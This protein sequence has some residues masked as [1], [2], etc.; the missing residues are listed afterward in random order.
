MAVAYPVEGITVDGDLS[1]WPE[2]MIAYPILFQDDGDPLHGSGDFGGSFRVGYSEQEN[3]LYIA[4][5]VEDDSVV[6]GQPG[7]GNYNTQDGCE[8]YL[9]GHQP[10]QKLPVQYYLRDPNRGTWGPDVKENM[11]VEAN[12]ED[13][14]YQ[15]EWRIDIGGA[16]SGGFFLR[17][18]TELGFDI[19]IWD[20][21]Q[22]G[23]A[24]W[25]AWSRGKGKY[26]N[27][28]ALGKLVLVEEGANVG[29]VLGLIGQAADDRTSAFREKVKMSVG[30]QMFFS[31]V[32]LAFTLLHL[33]LFLF[34][35]QTKANLFYSI[36]T[37]LIAVA[38][39]SGFQLEFTPYIDFGSISVLKQLALLT[40]QL[41]GLCFL[42]SL[43]NPKPPRRFWVL[44]AILAVLLTRAGL[45]VGGMFDF[46]NLQRDIAGGIIEALSVWVFVEILIALFKAVRNKK[47]GAWTIGIGFSFFA[48]NLSPLI[49]Q[50]GVEIDQLYWVL[51]PL[52]S[53]SIYLARSVTRTNKALHKQ[54]VQVEDLSNKTQEQYEQIQE[55]NLQIQEANRL[56][57]DF[58]ARM[59]HDLRTPM[60]AIIG[61]TRILLRKTKG[62]LDERQYRNLENVQ[63]SANNLLTL[64]NDVLDLSKIEAG[65]TDIKIGAVDLRQLVAECAASVESLLKPGVQLRQELD[66]ISPLRTD[67]DRMRR[68][69]MNLLSNA[70]KFTEEG[71]II[72]SLKAAAGWAELTVADTGVGIPVGDLPFIFDEFRQADRSDGGKQEGTGLGL[73]IVKRSVE[74]LGGT[75]RVE[76]EE[77][78]GAV[79]T[80]RIRDYEEG[81]FAE[82]AGSLSVSPV[83]R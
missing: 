27:T 42:Y 58:L 11:Q 54:L 55:Q 62:T 2:E 57:S 67:P 5:K 22:D 49:Y 82:T 44:V 18:E 66:Y 28:E 46:S 72:L 83:T 69:L 3:A 51:I 17:P 68:V 71:S 39:F 53:M 47:E 79:F 7:Q 12:W 13:R 16:S 45:F 38:V 60:N 4:V 26:A 1:D 70:V 34:D 40:V 77:G 21:D 35:P 31:G 80:L 20:K 25:I 81:P 29:K 50:N 30:Y 14:G 24:S 23:T 9:H 61:Y 37:G 59:S 33:L 41:F 63:I 48:F 76:S 19:S 64:I 6:R 32:L 75:V 74:L 73:A 36:Y 56:K 10:S 8:I 65:R 43:F 78:Q 15:L 52:I